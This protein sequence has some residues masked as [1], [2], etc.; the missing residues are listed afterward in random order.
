MLGR[1]DGVLNP[2][3]VRFGSAEIYNLLQNHFA[4]AVEDSLCIG[5][6]REYETDETV[7]LFLKMREGEEFNNRL[8]SSIRDVVRIELS[9]RHVPG[10]IDQCLE[11]PTTPNGKKVEI[12]IKKILSGE[13]VQ[14]DYSGNVVNPDCLDWYREWARRQ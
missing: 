14:T 8:A 12:L 11:I 13:K 10:L 1:S 6:Q 4:H 7:I 5:R 9:P 2:C 3:G